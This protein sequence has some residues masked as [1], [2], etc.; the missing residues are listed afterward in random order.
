[1]KRLLIAL[2]CTTPML[3]HAESAFHPMGPNLTYGVNNVGQSAITSL[4]NPATAASALRNDEDSR[5]RMGLV[6]VGVGYEVGDVANFVDELDLLMDKTDNLTLAEVTAIQTS[7]PGNLLDEFNVFLPKAGENGYMSITAGAQVL[8]PL[9][10]ASDSLG[11]AISLDLNV[12]ANVKVGILDDVITITEIG[13]AAPDY[14][15]DEIL[16]AG[17]SSLF[18]QG[19]AISE[20]ALGY[21]R[22]VMSRGNG[23]LYVG[24][25]LKL[26]NAEL[27]RTTALIDDSADI[28]TAMDDFDQNSIESSAT[29]VD[30]GVLWVT[31]NYQLGMTVLNATAPTFDYP[32]V[33]TTNCTT[34]FSGAAQI[35]CNNAIADNEYEMSAQARLEGSWHTES[36]NWLITAAYDANE[37]ETPTGDAVQWAVVGLAYAPESWWIPNFRVGHRANMTGSELSYLTA[38]L[39]LFKVMTLDVAYS[40]DTTEIDGEDTPRSV[41]ANL[42]FELRF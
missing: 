1:M 24:G 38:G 28:D 42:A 41:A 30:L 22:E 23:T 40:S 13:G 26:L 35:R 6:S 14:S 27:G 17:N 11:G 36:R 20:I 18:I 5:F 33:T 15:G 16:S 37:T 7:A 10:V 31:D 3:A 8:T 2:L 4:N 12:A 9:I 34:D 19:G 32:E 39:T 29:T 25:K 21:S